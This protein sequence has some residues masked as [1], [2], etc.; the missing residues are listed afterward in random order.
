[1]NSSGGII[2]TPE[3]PRGSPAPGGPPASLATRI[4]ASKEDRILPKIP[5]EALTDQLTS[6]NRRI[7]GPVGIKGEEGYRPGSHFHVTSEEEAHALETRQL[8]VRLIPVIRPGDALEAPDDETGD[9]LGW[10]LQFSPQDYLAKWPNGPN[11]EQARRI[12][13]AAQGS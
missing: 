13:A 5:M 7:S 10:T 12:L 9:P 6:T 1:M 11:A 2:F 4:P 8:A 3:P